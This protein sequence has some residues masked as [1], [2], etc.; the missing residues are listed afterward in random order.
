[1]RSRAVVVLARRS[2]AA[3]QNSRSGS[4]DPA[5]GPGERPASFH[6]SLHVC[7]HA[8]KRFWQRTSSAAGERPSAVQERFPESSRRATGF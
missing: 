7:R 3:L 4:F 2:S 5:A 6:V 8:W 1:M